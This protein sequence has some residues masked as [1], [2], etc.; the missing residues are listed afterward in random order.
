MA[1]LRVLTT[2]ENFVGELNAAGI[3]GV[4][5]DYRPTMAYD[6][7]E[8]IFEILIT[9]LTLEAFKLFGK[10]VV[11]RFKKT[12]PK[13]FTIVGGDNSVNIINYIEGETKRAQTRKQTPAKIAKRKKPTMPAASKQ[14]KSSGS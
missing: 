4:R 3:E 9:G 7:A 1:E 2:D 8:H 11:Q 5:A 14:K 12:P 13:Q 6:S 10:W